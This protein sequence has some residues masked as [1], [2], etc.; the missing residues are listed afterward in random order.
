MPP[1]IQALKDKDILVREETA[2]ALGGIDDSSI[3]GPLS[4][5]MKDTNEDWG[6]RI[7]AA[8]GLALQRINYDYALEFLAVT[9]TRD[10][11]S[12]HR[13]TAAVALGEIKDPRTIKHLISAL[14]DV[15]TSAVFA[16]QEIGEPAV[17]PLITIISISDIDDIAHFFNVD[18]GACQEWW[19]KN[20]YRV[21]SY[22]IDILGMIG[23][24]RAVD[25][26]INLLKDEDQSIQEKTF[27]ALIEITGK[28]FG[29]DYGAWQE[30]WEKNKENILMDEK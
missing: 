16:L 17:E 8:R 23:D 6:V 25:P 11:E 13:C 14:G 15:S 21:R 20:E 27:E 4:G 18:R 19:E 22:A 26:L 28:D 1:L 29:V 5:L 10:P 7:G 3:V 24:R 30:W 9:L 12:L 2:W